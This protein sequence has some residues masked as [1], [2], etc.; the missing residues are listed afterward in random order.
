MKIKAL[1]LIILLFTSC[2]FGGSLQTALIETQPLGGRFVFI[3]EV[4]VRGGT[5]SP[6]LTNYLETPQL[7]YKAEL[8]ALG[9]SWK[10]FAVDPLD[11]IHSRSLPVIEEEEEE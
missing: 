1:V 11:L 7:D 10:L 6:I 8:D 9:A 4:E 2:G 3:D 5:H